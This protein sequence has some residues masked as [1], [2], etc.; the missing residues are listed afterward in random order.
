M[1]REREADRHGNPPRPRGT[2]LASDQGGDRPGDRT[3]QVR[4]GG[5]REHLVS[6]APRT[7]DPRDPHDPGKASAEVGVDP[8]NRPIDIW[9]PE[10]GPDLSIYK[11]ML[12]QGHIQPFRMPGEMSRLAERVMRLM[13]I[14]EETGKVRDAMKCAEIL[15]MLAADNRAIA[16]ELD[17]VER[18]DAGKPTSISG[19]IDPEQAARI[20]RIM[21]TQKARANTEAGQ[22]GPNDP[23]DRSGDDGG[24][25]G[26]A[27][28]IISRI[29]A[30]GRADE[31]AQA[32]RDAGTEDRQ[33]GG[34]R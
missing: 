24:G 9:M 4:R 31:T 11:K 5:P 25:D 3:G 15:R 7:S 23:R 19:Q 26:E 18:L 29:V 10:N 8:R 22:H 34:A 14:A 17:R 27:A 30:A 6:D 32:P 16:V 33:D 1:A 20:K 12:M 21:S 13:D 2:P 28:Q